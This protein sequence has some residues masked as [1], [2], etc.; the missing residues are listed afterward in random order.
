MEN[1]EN[2]MLVSPKTARKSTHI[3]TIACLKC[4]CFTYQ[5]NLTS[6]CCNVQQTVL[7]IVHAKPI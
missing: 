3:T 7:V 5:N 2:K 1:A 6:I 4:T